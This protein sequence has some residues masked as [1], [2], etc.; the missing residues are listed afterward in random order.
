MK[1]HANFLNEFDADD[2]A[3]DYPQRLLCFNARTD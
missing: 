3:S 2:E 1:V